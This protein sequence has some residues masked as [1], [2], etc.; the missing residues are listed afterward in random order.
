MESRIQAQGIVFGEHNKHIDTYLKTT[1]ELLVQVSCFS[2]SIIIDFTSK[3]IIF[4]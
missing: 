4:D 1:K 2:N 3:F